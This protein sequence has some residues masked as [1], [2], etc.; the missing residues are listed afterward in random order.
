MRKTNVKRFDFATVETDSLED[1]LDFCH[2]S[3]VID[4][5]RKLDDTKVAWTL[6]H[7]FFT[8]TA[9][10]IPINCSEMRIVRTFLA[11]SEAL[12]IPE[13]DG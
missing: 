5:S 6:S 3:I 12:L 9:F 4:W 7:V 13:A 1:L 10:E 11:R 8:S 2:E